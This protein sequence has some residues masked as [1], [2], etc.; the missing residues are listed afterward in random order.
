MVFLF[1]CALGPGEKKKQKMRKRRNNEKN[2]KTRTI[3]RGTRKEA[4]KNGTNRNNIVVQEK[5][6]QEKN[7]RRIRKIT[8]TKRDR[9]QKEE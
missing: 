5:D 3:D 7:R 1:K 6:T 2:H 4:G 9:T 8:R